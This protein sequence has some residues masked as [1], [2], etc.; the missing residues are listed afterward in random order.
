MSELASELK[1]CDPQ[2]HTNLIKYYVQRE[3]TNFY[4]QLAHVVSQVLNPF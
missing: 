2:H 1:Y 3:P 4:K